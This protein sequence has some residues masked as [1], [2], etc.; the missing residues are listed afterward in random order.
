MDKN[1]VLQ[2]QQSQEN[3]TKEVMSEIKEEYTKT[4]GFLEENTNQQL[5]I[6][7]EMKDEMK[8]KDFDTNIEELK[9]LKEEITGLKAEIKRL[10]EMENIGLS[11]LIVRDIKSVGNALM[12]LQE[13]AIGSIKHLYDNMKHQLSYNLTKAQE[14]FVQIKIGIVKGLVNSMQDFIREQQKKL[15]SCLEKLDNLSK[16]IQKDEEKLI[17]DGQNH[18]DNTRKE[19][20]SIKHN[21]DKQQEEKETTPTENEEKKE[22]SSKE[23]LKAEM[24]DK[25]IV[26]KEEKEKPK[27]RPAEK[28]PS[29]LKKL[30]EN[31]QKI[32]K[33]EK[34]RDVKV[35]KKDKGMEL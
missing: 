21:E 23:I 12:N 14:K 22:I 20:I 34:A 33:E 26:K 11:S 30:K 10:N 1:K 7:K 9:A 5:N 6:A 2:S 17:Q 31:Q 18:E 25:G 24:A 27:E 19:D 15:D 29:V 4:T 28:K 3:R 13:K 32:K 16:E 35:P 8:N